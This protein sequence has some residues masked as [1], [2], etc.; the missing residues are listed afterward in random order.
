MPGTSA[1]GFLPRKC[2]QNKT[3]NVAG[4]LLD[5]T[6]PAVMGILNITPDSFH[7]G[8]RFRPDSEEMVDTAGHML[9]EGAAFLDIGG[10]STRPGAA[11]ISEAEEWERVGPVLEK[12]VVTFPGVRLSIDTFRADIAR[13]AID[14]GACLINDVSGGN[15]DAQ[16][17]ETVAQLGVP[18]ILMHMRGTPQTMTK[19][20][21]YQNL[22]PDVLQELQAKLRVL[23]SLGVA[24]VIVD[25]GFGFAKTVPQNFEVLNALD[26]FH[27]LDVPLL[28][29]LSRK[30][31]IWRTLGVTAA[32]ALNG[33]T[34]LNTLALQKGA[35]LLRVHDVRPACE[36]IK[37]WQLTRGEV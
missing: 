27:E 36:A 21:T 13:R 28:V 10:Y 11:E 26:S 18:Y 2:M 15:L 19:L 5:L 14:S 16:M 6:T 33:T 30:S 20:T 23:R 37:L 24:D 1:V 7:A 25:P 9:A 35:S 22:V 29:G 31:M 34:V 3:L 8:S 32:E 17:F 12:L 4:Q